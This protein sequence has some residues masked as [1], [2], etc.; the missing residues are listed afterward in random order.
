MGNLCWEFILILKLSSGWR[1]SGDEAVACSTATAFS[2]I[3]SLLE[4]MS[5]TP[6]SDC[7]WVRPSLFSRGVLYF[8]PFLILDLPSSGCCLR[9][10]FDALRKLLMRDIMDGRNIEGLSGKGASATDGIEASW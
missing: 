7:T 3:V 4:A 5:D 1:G 9:S 10:E 8:L 2:T 6:G